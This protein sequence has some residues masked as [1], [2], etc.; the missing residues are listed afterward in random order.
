MALDQWLGIATG[1]L[2][3]AAAVALASHGMSGG[4]LWRA[5]PR[6][7]VCPLSRRRVECALVRDVRTGQF[8]RVESCTAFPDPGDVR[9]AEDCRSIMNLG[10]PLAGEQGRP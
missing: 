9:C 8:Q 1:L 4:R 5:Q 3:V 7:F 10:L 2:L 6:R